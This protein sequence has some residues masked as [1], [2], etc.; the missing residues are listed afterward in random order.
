MQRHELTWGRHRHASQ[1]EHDWHQR[2]HGW[3][4]APSCRC[5]DT[6]E[7]RE[8][9]SV[10][11]QNWAADQVPQADHASATSL[12]QESNQGSKES[13]SGRPREQQRAAARRVPRQGRTWPPQL[14][15][16]SKEGRPAAERRACEHR[17]SHQRR[18]PEG[19]RCGTPCG[20]NCGDECRQKSAQTEEAQAASS[21]PWPPFF[22][23]FLSLSGPPPP[24]ALFLRASCSSF[25]KRVCLR[26]MAW[27]FCSSAM[28]RS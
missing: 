21:A 23:L 6:G 14:L 26:V 22:F 5:R 1:H 4:T 25:H 9:N 28:C 19:I 15:Q 24:P 27:A 2:E 16:A 10:V 7:L 3:M 11:P 8:E 17:V 20:Q 13:E 18:K 12:A